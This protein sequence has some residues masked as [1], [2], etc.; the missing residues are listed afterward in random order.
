ASRGCARMPRELTERPKAHQASRSAAEADPAR[1]QAALEE[2]E[3]RR[4]RDQLELILRS[5]SEGVMVQTSQRKFIFAN[6]AAARL[7]DFDSVDAL[8]AATR[9]EIFNRFEV[10]REDG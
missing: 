1:R 8:L 4:S 7:C 2:R 3:M 10:L 6:E 5:I 9:E